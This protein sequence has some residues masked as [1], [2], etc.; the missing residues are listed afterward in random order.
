MTAVSSTSALSRPSIQQMLPGKA[1][2]T[3][4]TIHHLHSSN[5][6]ESF[7]QLQVHNTTFILSILQRYLLVELTPAYR[8]TDNLM[9]TGNRGWFRND[10][11]RLLLPSHR[12]Q[13][14][15]SSWLTT[16]ITKIRISY[17]SVEGATL[18]VRN[19]C[20]SQNHIQCNNIGYHRGGTD[21]YGQRSPIV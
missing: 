9:H 10:S 4:L 5:S 16:Q 18:L 20:L 2:F 15:P 6:T 3:R 1:V 17:Q 14:A 19:V 11:L 12:R 13:Q 8:G 7:Q 21:S